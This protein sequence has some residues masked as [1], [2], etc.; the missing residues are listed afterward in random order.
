MT[1]PTNEEVRQQFEAW[2]PGSGVEGCTIEKVAAWYG[3]AAGFKAA[4][5]ACTPAKSEG[6]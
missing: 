4:L 1:T 2:Y 3:Y 5:A 6:R